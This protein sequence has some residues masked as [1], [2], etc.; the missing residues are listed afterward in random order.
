MEFGQSSEHDWPKEYQF[1]AINESL[2][3]V[4]IDATIAISCDSL[5]NQAVGSYF[6]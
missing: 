1:S 2:Q 3:G 4:Y 6:S 5:V